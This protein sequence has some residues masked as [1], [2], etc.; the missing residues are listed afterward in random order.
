MN[1]GKHRVKRRQAR[2][3]AQQAV[4]QVPTHVVLLKERDQAWAFMRACD[5]VGLQAGFPSLREFTVKVAVGSSRDVEKLHQLVLEH[6]GA[7]DV[8]APWSCYPLDPIS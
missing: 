7:R 8:T 2:R 5:R 6:V 1:V 4:D 3:R